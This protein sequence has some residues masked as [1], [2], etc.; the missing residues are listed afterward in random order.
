[1][2]AGVTGSVIEADSLPISPIQGVDMNHLTPAVLDVFER[3]HGIAT[4][5][6]LHEA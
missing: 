2:S 6:T 4:A 1:M 5:A 3:Q